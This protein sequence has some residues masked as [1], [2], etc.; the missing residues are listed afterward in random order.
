[1]N[2]GSS[3]ELRAWL[4]LSFSQDREH[5]GN[6]GYEEDPTRV[7]RYDNFVANHKRVHVGDLLVIR[8]R[9]HLVGF[10][11]IKEI[12]HEAGIKQFLRC[13]Q[14]LMTGIKRR[15]TNRVPYRC[16]KGHEFDEPV[17]E[18]K[19]CI[20]YEARYDERF[21]RAETQIPAPVLRS[22]CYK[23]ADQLAIQALDFSRIESVALDAASGLK[24][25]LETGV[26]IEE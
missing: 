1:M 13:P 24:H 23:Y 3:N 17:L 6:L 25:L 5:A 4:V 11:K 19:Q 14:C 20:L 18:K 26:A 9:S 8:E 7:Y 15:S 16:H 12:R 22:A 21:V 10:A 2:I